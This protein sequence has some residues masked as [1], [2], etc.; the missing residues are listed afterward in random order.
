MGKMYKM[1]TFYSL[2]FLFGDIIIKF[3]K[4]IPGPN[5]G[6]NHCWMVSLQFLFNIGCY[7][8]FCQPLIF[9]GTDLDAHTSASTTFSKLAYGYGMITSVQEHPGFQKSRR[10]LWVV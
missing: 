9:V 3:S 6:R 2:V 10:T 5:I 7:L 4:E 8:F 1:L